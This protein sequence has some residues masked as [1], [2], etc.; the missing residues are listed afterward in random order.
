[1]S[2]S[3][4]LVDRNN[5]IAIHSVTN[6]AAMNLLMHSSPSSWATVSLGYLSRTT[7]AGSESILILKLPKY[8]QNDLRNSCTYLHFSQQCMRIPVSLCLAS[9]RV[10]SLF[11]LYLTYRQ[12][13]A[14]FHLDILICELLFDYFPNGLFIYFILIWSSYI[15]ETNTTW[16]CLGF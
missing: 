14:P 9:T 3:H 16:L 8:W 1:M 11:N 7:I 10:T 15:L 6:N 12:L 4:S 2:N 5:I 13:C